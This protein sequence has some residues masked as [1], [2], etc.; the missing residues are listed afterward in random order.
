MYLS[1]PTRIFP[2]VNATPYN[3]HHIATTGFPR[4][5]PPIRKIGL[6][7]RALAGMIPSDK[8]SETK[9]ARFESSLER[10]FYVLLEFNPLV[11]R[12]DPQ[13]VRLRVDEGSPSYVPDV[14]VSYVRDHSDPGSGYRVLY[15]IKHREELRKNWA[16]FKPRFKAA[17]RYA[18]SQGWAF[19]IATEREIR[20]SDLL[21]NAKFLLP[22]THDPIGDGEHALLIKMLRRLDLTTPANLL[23]ACASDPWEQARLL[24]ALWHLVA[25]REVKCDLSS[26]LTMNS[27]IWLHD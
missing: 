17:R 13:P 20:D 1:K 5:L 22:Y 21:W 12:W 7:R 2:G 26:R 23:A 15:E 10:D 19:R 16:L 8:L 24:S 25:V 3:F 14:L 18:K 4:L 6:G 11:L 27:E 9:I